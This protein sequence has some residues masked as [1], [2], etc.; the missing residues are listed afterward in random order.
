MKQNLLILF[1][2]SVF[3]LS[4]CRSSSSLKSTTSESLSERFAESEK[5]ESK[6]NTQETIQTKEE[7]TEDI[8]VIVY[9][10]IYTSPKDS[11]PE[12]FIER[13]TLT[14]IVR[15][16]EQEQKTEKK[17]EQE[18]SSEYNRESEVQD[19]VSRHVEEKREFN[20]KYS[21]FRS[22]IVWVVIIGALSF[23]FIKRKSIWQKLRK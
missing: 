1:V 13:L 23:L 12:R 20:F 8:E 3:L 14:T 22:V 4:G 15:K 21:F 10:R 19:T 6:V 2:G 7:Q 9:E 11:I 18:T 16:K 17:E 5:A